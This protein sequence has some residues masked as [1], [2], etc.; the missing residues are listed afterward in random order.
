M[1]SLGEMHY[2]AYNDFNKPFTTEQCQEI[3][4]AFDGNK[5]YMRRFTVFYNAI[6]NLNQTKHKKGESLWPMT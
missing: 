1:L 3:H 4:V 6:D 5:T 2:K